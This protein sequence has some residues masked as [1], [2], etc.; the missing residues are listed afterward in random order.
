MR[1]AGG[2]AMRRRTEDFDERGRHAAAGPCVELDADPLTR[3]CEGHTDPEA[4]GMCHAVARRGQFFDV[5]VDDV[6]NALT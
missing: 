1:T 5:D 3:Q 2:D 4:S 6:E